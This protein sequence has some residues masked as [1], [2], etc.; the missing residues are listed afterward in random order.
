MKCA[1]TSLLRILPNRLRTI[2]DTGFRND[3]QEIRL[4]IGRPPEIIADARAV[5]LGDH[6]GAEDLS[7]CINASSQYSPW[8]AWTSKYGYLTVNGGHRIGICGQ[9]IIQ[10]GEVASITDVSS[11]CIRVARDFSG[12]IK[13][14]KLLHGSVLIIGKPGSGKTTLLRDLIRFRSAR[15][16][17]AVAVVDEKQEIFPVENGK[18]CFPPGERTDVISCCSKA[19]GIDCML[20]NMG[21]ATIAVDE[22]TSQEDCVALSHAGFCGTDLL[23][24]AHAGSKKDLYSR[25][26][27]KPIMDTNIFTHLIILQSDKTWITE[28]INQ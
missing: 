18:L 2:V 28:R 24:T 14:D 9:A 26:V 6:V 10:N 17:G 25:S 7:Y 22:I 16:F 13:E 3:L 8:S 23:A 19:W 11:I 4:R 5:L 1:W 27:Y 20:R 12:L 15:G 21:P